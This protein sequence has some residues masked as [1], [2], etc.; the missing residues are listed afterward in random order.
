MTRSVSTSVTTIALA[1]TL[2]VS[3]AALAAGTDGWKTRSNAGLLLAQTDASGAAAEQ[4]AA[5][6]PAAAVEQPPVP[7]QP[8][9]A[10]VAEQ[11]APPPAAAE[12]PAAAPEPAP[13]PA[14]EAVPPPAAAEQPV[15]EQPAAEPAP[16]PAAE[17]PAPAEQPA[18]P[19]AEAQAPAEAA[20]QPAAE[21]QAPAA[22]AQAPEA[23]QT[24]PP[25]AE[26]QAEPQQNDRKKR[27]RAEDAGTGQAQQEQPPQPEAAPTPQA[28]EAPPQPSPEAQEAK[29]MA[30][31]PMQEIIEKAKDQ[32]TAVVPDRMTDKQR[33]ALQAAERTR[34]DDARKR[35]NELLG[36][37]AVGVAVGAMI[38]LLGGRVV[39]DQGDRFVVERN[40]QLFVRRDESARWRG[41]GALVE[42]EQLRRGRTRETV[43][44]RDGSQI[45]TVRD[46]GGYVLKRSR[47][48]RRGREI[49]LFDQRDED[50]GR[51]VDYDR[52]LPPLRFDLPRDQYV[53]SGRQAN[54]RAVRQT[55]LAP[56]VE[57]VQS[58]YTLRDVRENQRVR[59]IVRRVDLDSITF[60]TGSATVRESQVPY[61]GDI[62][63]GMLDV[64]EDNP[65]A[66]FLI[67]GHTDAVGSD[68]SNLVLS[69]RRAETVARILADGFGIPPE[70]MVTEGYGEQFL[71]VNTDA[72]ERQNRRVTI[73]N[74]TPLLTSQN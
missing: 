44:R 26:V 27:K 13:Q 28:A 60:D 21:A 57:T 8:A 38:P 49:V 11:P 65:A 46:A 4:P 19:A 1:L 50:R 29:P 5:E 45:V 72:D 20:P 30:E 35:R 62:A 18:P 55:F 6:Q 23:A 40:G 47:I 74:I 16:Q 9:P 64:I 43:T 34:R 73:R 41:D 12:Q 61:L 25:A 2:G 63:G 59:D 17:A 53:L 24:T 69:D 42:I 22:E 3:P 39:E 67:E 10:P 51:A 71:K 31:A 66:V 58:A 7:E 33:A 36:A 68:L 52:T 37:A 15:A 48:T 56:P 32:Q 54:R 14:A 70:N